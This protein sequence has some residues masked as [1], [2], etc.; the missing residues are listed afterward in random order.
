[1]SDQGALRKFGEETVMKVVFPIVTLSPDNAD[2]DDD[3]LSDH[4][5]E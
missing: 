5:S 3:T 1:M 2:D 4:R